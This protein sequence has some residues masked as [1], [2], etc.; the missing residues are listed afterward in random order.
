VDID[1]ARKA[2]AL[3]IISIELDKLRSLSYQD[4]I[5]DF[6]VEESQQKK[7]FNV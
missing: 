1:A 2:F 7:E 5:S 4:I 6:S 3:S